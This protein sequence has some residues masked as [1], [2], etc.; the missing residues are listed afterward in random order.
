MI[1]TLE[2][3]LNDLADRLDSLE[4]KVNNVKTIDGGYPNAEGDFDQPESEWVDGGDGVNDTQTP[5]D[6]IADGGANN[7]EGYD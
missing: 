6:P 5:M 3:K 4:D 7:A 2:N 1:E